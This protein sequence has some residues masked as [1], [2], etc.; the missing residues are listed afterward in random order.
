MPRI[1]FVDAP[2]SA[3]LRQHTEGSDPG[4]LR[5]DRRGRWWSYSVHQRGQR[6]GSPG[7]AAA[8][9]ETIRQP[10]SWDSSGRTH[11]HE[12][13]FVVGA[14]TMVSGGCANGTLTFSALAL[15]SAGEIARGL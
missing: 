1:S 15:R 11:D 10:A 14:P 4:R 5:P 3:A 8:A 9:W 12:N 7:A 2:E 13:L 6:P